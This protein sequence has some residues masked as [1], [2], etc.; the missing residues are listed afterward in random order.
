M[1]CML[2]SQI[3]NIV[4]NARTL[5]KEEEK[6]SI[7]GFLEHFRWGFSGNHGKNWVNQAINATLMTGQTGLDLGRA[8]PHC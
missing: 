3:Y 2:Q 1:H 8:W 4:F 6:S 7:C 5:G